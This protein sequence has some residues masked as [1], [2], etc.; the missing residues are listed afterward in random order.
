[1]K[2]GNPLDGM[3]HT[4]CWIGR[5]LY[6]G[7]PADFRCLSALLTVPGRPV[8]RYQMLFAMQRNL[9]PSSMND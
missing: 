9:R 8:E 5:R 2:S 4:I 1:M 7:A 3:A 6:L